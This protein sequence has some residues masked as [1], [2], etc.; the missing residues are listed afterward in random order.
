MEL[1]SSLLKNPFRFRIL[2][3]TFYILLKALILVT[4]FWHLD[5]WSLNLFAFGLSFKPVSSI[6]YMF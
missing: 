3:S 6:E 1:C 4:D 5:P 2:K